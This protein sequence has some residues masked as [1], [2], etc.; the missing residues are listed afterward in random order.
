MRHFF[1]TILITIGFVLTSF[2][3]ETKLWSE[4]DRKYLIDNLTRTRESVINETKNLSQAQWNFKELPDRWSINQIVEHLAYWELLLEREVSQALVA[5]PKPELTK[6]AKTDSSVIAFLKEERQH[7]TTEY[8]KPFTFTVPMGLNE[9]KNNLAW[10]LN[11]RNEGIGFTDS[12]TTDLRYYFLRP[13][14]GNVHQVFITIFA[15][16][17]R[18]LK[19]I[20][21]VKLNK[22]FPK[23]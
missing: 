3:Q 13:G 6:N 12:T 23:Q 8:T 5:G 2:A 22:N 4:E 17:D 16:T 14:R 18:H 21:K 11:M 1:F 7:I 15:H 20:R 9:G 19:Q 10:F